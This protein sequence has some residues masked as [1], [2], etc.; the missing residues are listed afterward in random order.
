ME[1]MSCNERKKRKK[2]HTKSACT[3]DSSVFLLW[4]ETNKFLQA[5]KML[6]EKVEEKKISSSAGCVHLISDSDQS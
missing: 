6:R 2:G 4:A 5:K 1:G 3:H